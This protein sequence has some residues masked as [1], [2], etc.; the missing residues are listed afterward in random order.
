M[1][2][3]I[4]HYIILY[5]ILKY[6]SADPFVGQG[7]RCFATTSNR[8]GDSRSPGDF[9][10]SAGS[11]KRANSSCFCTRPWHVVAT[12]EDLKERNRMKA[13]AAPRSCLGAESMLTQEMVKG[14]NQS[15]LQAKFMSFV[16]V[17][18]KRPGHVV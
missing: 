14:A 12:E 7:Q 6:I 2:C 5:F 8:G 4:L 15:D 9:Q 3:I 13:G 17:T 18:S 16:S 10:E 1:H 11:Q